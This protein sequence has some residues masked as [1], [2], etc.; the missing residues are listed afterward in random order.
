MESAWIKGMDVSFLDEIE[1]GGGV[2]HD[3]T[4]S[5][6]ALRILRDGGVNSIRLRIWNDPPGTYCNLERTLLMAK[7]VKALGMQLLLDFHY[8]DRWADP[9]NQWKP[10]LWTD[11]QGRE[12]EQAVY[13]YTYEVL[14]VLRAGGAL[15]D[16]VQIGNE[17][18]YGMLWPDG[19]IGA[20]EG[21]GEAEAQWVRLC[22]LLKA[23]IGAYGI[24]MSPSGSCCISTGAAIRKGAGR[25][26]TGWKRKESIMT[27]SVCLIILGGTARWSS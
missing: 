15:P 8:S 26:S 22:G 4:E 16:M 1:Q 12:L 21:P 9:A 7:R 13:D 14:A 25:S 10:A 11:L 19:R 27:S 2:F 5:G 3:A 23:G 17:I 24:R 18:T 20:D 6:D